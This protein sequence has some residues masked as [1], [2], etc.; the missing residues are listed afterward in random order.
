MRA[1]PEAQSLGLVTAVRR[2]LEDWLVHLGCIAAP[3]H[4]PHTCACLALCAGQAAAVRDGP[5]AR[6]TGSGSGSASTPATTAAAP[7]AATTSKCR[8]PAPSPADEAALL[9]GNRAAL[10]LAMGAARPGM[11][12]SH[13]PQC[14]LRWRRCEVLVRLSLATA[15]PAVPSF[16][17][18]PP[19]QH[20]ACRLSTCTH[21]SVAFECWCASCCAL[22]ASARAVGPLARADPGGTDPPA[23]GWQSL[24]WGTHARRS[25]W[26]R[27]HPR[28]W[29][30]ALQLRTRWQVSV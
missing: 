26:A 30:A 14:A 22:R 19:G 13:G 11:A 20:N 12:A 18:P 17:H 28:P 21:A 24:R 2:Q 16:S 29:H 6:A 5:L 10:L 27:Q 8:S 3:A 1:L 4:M 25:R 15:V 23:V 9:L 7:C